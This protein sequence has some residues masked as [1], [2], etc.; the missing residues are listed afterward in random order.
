MQINKETINEDECYVVRLK[1]L[2]AGIAAALALMAIFTPLATALVTYTRADMRM[3]TFIT[4]EEAGRTYI[5]RRAADNLTEQRNAQMN[6]LNQNI[7]TIAT[8]QD[9]LNGNL[10][11]LMGKLGVEAT[12]AMR[13]IPNAVLPLARNPE[14]EM[15]P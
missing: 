1:R 6:A 2:Q 14:P 8:N 4:R 11:R 5:T 10:H 9:A 12:A 15:T 7:V 3:A 13:P